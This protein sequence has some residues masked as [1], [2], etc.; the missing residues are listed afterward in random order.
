M[1]TEGWPGRGARRTR[2]CKPRADPGQPDGR[3]AA[4]ARRAE[5]RPDK[6]QA[7][8]VVAS[9]LMWIL[10]GWYWYL[11]MQRQV[12]PS[13]LRAVGLLLA[14]SVLGI[15]ISFPLAHYVLLRVP[16]LGQALR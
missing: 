13:S 16:V 11:V 9:I 1:M 8:H 4:R 10:F 14:I 3:A 7:W 15:G 6:R 2:Q 5:G 12:S